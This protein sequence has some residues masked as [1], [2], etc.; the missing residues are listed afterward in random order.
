M[1]IEGG[2]VETVR[3]NAGNYHIRITRQDYHGQA[4]DEYKASV[5]RISDDVELRFF[6]E[7]KWLLEWKIKPW[8]LDRAFKYYDKRQKKLAKVEKR[9]I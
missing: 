4:N 3:S 6:S 2:L 7:W 5:T 9:V 8:A 1:K